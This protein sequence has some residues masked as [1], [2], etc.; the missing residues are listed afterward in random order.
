MRTSYLPFLTVSFDGFFN[1]LK[2]APVILSRGSATEAS[3]FCFGDSFLVAIG[4]FLRADLQDAQVH[5]H[6][7]AGLPLAQ[8]QPHLAQIFGTYFR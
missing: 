8:P 4:Y 3:F 6:P 1:A 2:S 5:L 7:F